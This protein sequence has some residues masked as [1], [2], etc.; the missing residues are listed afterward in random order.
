MMCM[1]P[2]CGEPETS[3]VDKVWNPYFCD[4]HVV[5][6]DSTGKVEIYMSDMFTLRK[7]PERVLEM[8]Q[9][10]LEGLGLGGFFHSI[11]YKT[12]RNVYILGMGFES[13]K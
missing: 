5:E 11:E 3:V 2:A 12:S 9:R 4:R 10:D 1:V 6:I 8:F 7:D 13:Q